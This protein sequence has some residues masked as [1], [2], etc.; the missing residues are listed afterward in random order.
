MNNRMKALSGHLIRWILILLALFVIYFAMF[1]P[2]AWDLE[3]VVHYSLSGMESPDAPITARMSSGHGYENLLLVDRVNGIYHHMFVKKVF[4]LLWMN[5]GGGFGMPIHSD[6]LLNFRGGM[7]TF[8]K[9]QHYYYLGQVND[10]NISKLHIKWHDGY[11]QDIAIN[12]GFYLTVHTR[13]TKA[14]KISIDTGNRLFAY[15]TNDQ[16]LYELNEEQR[17]IKMN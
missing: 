7:S 14:Q 12:D 9:Y 1:T 4:G 8:G 10:P 11:E 15:D 6:I 16:L 3:N 13:L 2:K 5:K 17:E